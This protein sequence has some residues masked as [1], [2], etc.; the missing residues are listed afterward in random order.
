MN[1]IKIFFNRKEIK[2]LTSLL[3][4]LELRLESMKGKLAHSIDLRNRSEYNIENKIW[5]N[6]SQSDFDKVMNTCQK[7]VDLDEEEISKLK[8]EISL[9]K[10]RLKNLGFD[11]KK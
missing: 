5:Q 11:V 4:G 7:E 8:K 6:H 10:A 3:R 1:L 2:E 9:V